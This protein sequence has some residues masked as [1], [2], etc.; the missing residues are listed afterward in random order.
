MGAG[1]REGCALFRHW[2]KKKEKS[3]GDKRGLRKK[4]VRAYNLCLIIVDVALKSVQWLITKSH[5]V[6][7]QLSHEWLG[8]TSELYLFLP[9]KADRNKEKKR[10]AKTHLISHP[11]DD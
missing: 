6:Q 3:V 2:K 9:P 4:E 11:T 7:E 1:G 10:K 8:S 5:I